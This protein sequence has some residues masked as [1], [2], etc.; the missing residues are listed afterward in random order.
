MSDCGDCFLVPISFLRVKVILILYPAKLI[1]LPF[2][3]QF[4]VGP[5]VLS[6]ILMNV[7]TELHIDVSSKISSLSS[8]LPNPRG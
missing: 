2:G 8:A 1:E 6:V 7:L 3:D 5:L 4:R